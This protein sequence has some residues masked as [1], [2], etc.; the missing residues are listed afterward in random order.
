MLMLLLLMIHKLFLFFC[1]NFYAN[2]YKSSY[3]SDSAKHFL[4]PLTN[5]NTISA[6]EKE[7]CDQDLVLEEVVD[8]IKYLKCNKSPGNDGIVADFYKQFSDTLAPFLLNVFTESIINHN[9][10]P[11][12][13]QGKITI[14]PKPKKYLLLIE[15]WRPISLLNNDYKILALIL[16]KRIKNVLNSIIDETQSGF[17]NNRHIS[18]NIR[19]VLDILDYLNLIS[20]DSFLLFLDFYKAFDTLEHHFNF[21][22]LEK[23]VY[24]IF[25]VVP[26]KHYI[27]TVVVWLFKNI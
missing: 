2:L 10:P 11:S 24:G 25:F 16:S 19:L 13:S 18:N 23:F 12:L 4:D 26:L 17:L 1:Y 6:L 9:L 5:T 22:C 8:A 14:I 21:Q 7:C 15:N 27:R 3:C 20:D